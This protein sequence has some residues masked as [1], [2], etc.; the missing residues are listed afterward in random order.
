[1]DV[2]DAW[3]H[4]APARGRALLELPGSAE[5]AHRPDGRERGSHNDRGPE[6][7]QVSFP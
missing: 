3:E 5:L 2:R 1:V 6:R 4:A 7:E